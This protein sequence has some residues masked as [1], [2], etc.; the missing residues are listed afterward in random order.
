MKRKEFLKLAA[1]TNLSLLIK[2]LQ[3]FSANL[4]TDTN[5][6]YFK[7]GDVAYETLR[8]GFNKRINKF[9]AAIA[10]CHNTQG[11]TEAVQYGIANKLPITIKSGGH[12]MEGFSSNNN[13]LVINLSELNK[14]SWVDNNT[15]LVGP[16]CT[17]SNL[18]DNIL[19]KGKILPGGSCGGVGIGGLTLGGGYGLLARN[20]GLT[21]DS[22]QKVTM[23]DGQGK[24]RNSTTEPD[25][26]WA[27]KGG[28]NGN[29]GAITE[30]KF[31]LHKAPATL[32][33]HRFKSFKVDGVR[34]KSIMQKWFTL[35]ATLPVECFSAFILNGKTVYILLTNTGK[36]SAAVQ[37]FI[38]QLSAV[39]DKTIKG[40]AQ[41]IAKALK[42]F[43]GIQHPVYF[44]NASA[45]LYKNFSDIDKCINAVIEKVL[46]TPRMIYQVNTLGG[47]I[48]NP[49]FEKASSFAHRDCMY[50]SELQT[51]W[52]DEKQAPKLM[53]RFEE[54][55][56]IFNANGVTAQYKNYPDIN[57]KNYDNLYYGKNFNKL[58]Q[59][60][61]LYD[62][63]NVFSYEQS[64][65]K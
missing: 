43:Y 56:Q 33:S 51:Y 42:V 5:V 27:C 50:F 61:T 52:E 44:K 24:I 4:P 2:P 15:I 60:K 3:L 17:L 40:S 10:L 41:N 65:K 32:Q 38:T 64:I 37:N 29:F 22:L 11:V 36:N 49:A 55:Q 58:Q 1:L 16:A 6:T 46:T 45:G 8:L 28:A 47:N 23:V 9:P 31:K 18:Y 7:K 14:I 48:T 30:L 13:G 12:C 25:L 21:C 53:Q 20:Y 34:A 63:N 62:P 54:V 19:P 59:L 39:S 26:L 57:F 35:A